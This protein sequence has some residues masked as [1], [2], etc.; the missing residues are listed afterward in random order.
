MQDPDGDGLY[1]FVTT[2]IPAGSYEGKVALNESWDLN[3]GANGD[4]NGA[5]IAFTVPNAGD[6]VTFSYNASSHLPTIVVES[7]NSGENLEAIVKAPARHPV[8]NDL[9]YFVMPDRFAN[10]SSAND[11]GGLS[12]TRSV[13]GFDPTDKGYYHGGD[14]AGLL[15]KLDYLE[16]MG[17]SA[18]W[19]TPMFK[20]K[21]VQG[22]GANESAGYHGYWTVDYSQ[23]DPHFGSNAE[24][25]ALI[26]AA[27]A[28]GIKVFFDIITA[29]RCQP[30]L[31]L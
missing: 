22:S 18:I 27:H 10:G 15:G 30:Q 21:P 2:A 24:M 12:G 28:R 5:N 11:S 13:T 14:L 31:P 1:T 25:N 29:A 3:Y 7:A 8:Q 19:M 20:N 6:K 23:I 4:L 26:D 9:F 16:Q 17:V